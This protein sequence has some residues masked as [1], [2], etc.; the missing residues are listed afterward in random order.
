MR[1]TNDPVTDRNKTRHI[2]ASRIAIISN[3]GSIGLGF[4]IYPKY[5]FSLVANPYS[6]G[7]TIVLTINRITG[8]FATVHVFCKK[9][10]LFSSHWIKQNQQMYIERCHCA[11]RLK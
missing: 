4:C 6:L 2:A 11:N 7:T 8:L 1:M 10:L 9:Y 5:N 3:L